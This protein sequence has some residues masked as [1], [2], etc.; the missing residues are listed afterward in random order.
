MADGAPGARERRRTRRRTAHLTARIWRQARVYG[1]LDQ[2]QAQVA[3]RQTRCV[4]VAV[5]ERAWGFKSPLAHVGRFRE[6]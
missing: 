1:T 5:S 2:F 3:E 6:I 4:Q